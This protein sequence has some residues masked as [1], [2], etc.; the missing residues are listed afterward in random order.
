VGGDHEGTGSGPATEI[1]CDFLQISVGGD[2]IGDL[3]RMSEF[4]SHAES[5][6]HF[7]PD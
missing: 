1:G 7:G 2:C 3:H 6:A 5:L 4:G